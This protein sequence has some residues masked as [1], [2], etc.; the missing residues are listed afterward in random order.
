MKKNSNSKLL[1]KYLEGKCSP[2][3]LIEMAKWL[4]QSEAN[5]EM[6]KMMEEDW[7]EFQMPD[8]KTRMDQAY[9]ESS[10]EKMS[11]QIE[12]TKE[13]SWFK[14]WMKVAASIVI[15]FTVGLLVFQSMNGSE[16]YMTY[17]SDQ[18]GPIVYTLSDGS[19]V[20]LASGSSIS[21]PV[22]MTN[23][24]RQVFLSGEAFFDTRK[25]NRPLVVHAG[26]ISTTVDNSAL[27][28]SAFDDDDE[29]IVAVED[30]QAEVS[31]SKETTPLI[32]LIIP[33]P[34][35][36][37]PLV[38]LIPALK[39]RKTE[40]MAIN[41]VDGSV[42]KGENFDAKELFGWKDGLLYFNEADSSKVI[43]RL[44]RW[45]GVDIKV[46]GCITKNSYSGEFE[47]ES[48]EKIITSMMG[49]PNISY[50]I[51]GKTV[52]IEGACI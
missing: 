28:I 33:E 30:G 40:Y 24:N 20:T 36:S 2:K 21:Y 16:E 10:F 47:N 11:A 32:K 42:D 17:H 35:K 45:Y 51:R 48:L 3:E 15:V 34:V 22:N 31:E 49:A 41:K 43:K 8:Q 12:R 52:S 46:S 23:Q 50:E 4:E 25:T 19:K 29:V 14:P 6:L 27:S 13:T 38:K 39:L 5:Q 7:E 37:M 18:Q 9:F 1:E 26:N 44:E